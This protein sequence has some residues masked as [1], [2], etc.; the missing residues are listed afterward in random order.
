MINFRAV[1]KVKVKVTLFVIQI[2]EKQISIGAKFARIILLAVRSP[3]HSLWNNSFSYME[4][5]DNLKILT[6]S[7][8]LHPT[9]QFPPIKD[10]VI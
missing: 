1:F 8:V 9:M 7:L 6:R 2:N 10:G 5:T 4:Y 3:V